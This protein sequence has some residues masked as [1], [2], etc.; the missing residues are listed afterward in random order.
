MNNLIMNIP[1]I[2]MRPILY[3]FDVLKIKH[4]ENTLWLDFGVKCGG[5]AN[6]ISLK[7]DD[8]M[9]GF[10][11]NNGFPEKWE[12]DNY[13][14]TKIKD[15]LIVSNGPYNETVKNFITTQNKKISF[16]HIDCDYYSSTKYVLNTIKNYIDNDCIIIFDELVNYPGFDGPNGELKALYEF[17]TENN[18]ILNKG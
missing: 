2:R 17:I 16:I 6:Y 1:N 13:V 3:I 10:Y 8:K 14:F 9:Y 4:K 11:N 18:E 12:N 15:D 7:T 5:N